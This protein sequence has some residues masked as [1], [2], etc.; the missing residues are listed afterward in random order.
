MST[1]LVVQIPKRGTGI[2]PVSD[3]SSPTADRKEHKEENPG[4][5]GLPGHSLATTSVSPAG[6][7]F[8]ALFVVKTLLFAVL[9]RRIAH[10]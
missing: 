6:F 3:R 9:Y 7:V 1:E 2:L 10:F 4:S 5:V 8:S